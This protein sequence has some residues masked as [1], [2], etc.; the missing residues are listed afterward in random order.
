[1][2][3][4]DVYERSFKGKL[5]GKRI[6][7]IFLQKKFFVPMSFIGLPVVLIWTDFTLL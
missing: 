1:M 6:L 3:Y 5:E 4:F 7:N 2:L